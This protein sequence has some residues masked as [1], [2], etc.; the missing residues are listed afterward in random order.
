MIIKKLINY[1]VF[2]VNELSNWKKAIR[3]VTPIKYANGIRALF[4]EKQYVLSYPAGILPLIIEGLIPRRHAIQY[5]PAKGNCLT[6]RN[7][8]L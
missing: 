6:L 7:N 4:I 5:L 8:L 2:T 1:L 3:N